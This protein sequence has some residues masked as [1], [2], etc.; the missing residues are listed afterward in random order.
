MNKDW[1]ELTPE[2]I[3]RAEQLLRAEQ[4]TRAQPIMPE[5]I[6]IN[7]SD[8]PPDRPAPATSATI[9]TVTHDD[10][11][12]VGAQ[13][14]TSVDLQALEEGLYQ[15]VNNARSAHLPR[16]IGTGNLK[17]HEE[18]AAVARGHS[19]DMLKRQYVA[20]VSPEGISASRRIGQN[21][22]SYVACGEN[23]GIYYGEGAHTA[24]AIREIHDAFMN[25]PRS[26]TNH[27]GNLLNP[28]WTHVGIG[29]AYNPDGSLVATQ[30][31]IS[32]PAARIRGR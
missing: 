1:L 27:R 13:R 7:P 15:L 17:W 32:A 25:Q 28:L 9:I 23:I 31:F 19:A 21:G 5:I 24:Q 16:W 22:I 26:M 4:Q 29:I 2:D 6:T 11:A 3:E 20:H 14:D 8:I 18:L 30:N 10:L 12:P